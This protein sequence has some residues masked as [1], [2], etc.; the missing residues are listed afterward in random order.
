MEAKR[1]K[2]Q[3]GEHEEQRRKEEGGRWEGKATPGLE[4]LTPNPNPLT[5]TCLIGQA[6]TPTPTPMLLLPFSLRCCLCC[7]VALLDERCLLQLPNP[8]QSMPTCATPQRPKY[9]RCSMSIVVHHHQD[10]IWMMMQEAGRY[11]LLVD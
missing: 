6:S 5:P 3:R 8:H 1:G 9:S 2:E 7:W 11:L 4:G 10:L